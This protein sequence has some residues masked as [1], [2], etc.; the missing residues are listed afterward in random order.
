MPFGKGEVKKVGVIGG[1]RIPFARA[2]TAYNNIAPLRL[3][4]ASHQAVVEKYKLKG[5]VLG[6]VA[7]GGVINHSADWNL[8][9][10]SVFQS[11]LS[12][13]TPGVGV[14]RAC[15]TSLEAAIIIGSKIATGQIDS[16]L[17]GGVDSL[18]DVPVVYGRKLARTLL[19]M[20]RAKTFGARIGPFFKLGFRDLKPAFPGVTEPTTGMSMG[21]HCEVM[22]K[23]WKVTREEQDQLA[24]ESHQKAAAAWKD[25]FYSDLVFPFNG[26]ETDNNVRGNT[27]L[28][29]MA[30]LKPAFDRS[31]A[32][33][34]TAANS[35]A[36]TDGAASVLLGTDEWAQSKGLK[37]QAYISDS[38]VAAV[39]IKKE[40][41]LMAPA[42]AVGRML[43]RNNLKLQDF[44]FYE[45][46]EAFAAQ[47]L[48]TLK[49]WESDDFC[50]NR[51][52]LDGAL[53]SIDRSKMNV[54]G[55]S[56]AVGHPF[57]ATG[58]RLVA[59]LAKLLDQKG[60]GRGLISVCTGGGMGVTAILE[61]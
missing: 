52:G 37:V 27:T 57:G 24:F 60:S 8:A 45:I 29:K 7:S 41:L 38:E 55:G 3:L 43:K 26:L 25:G 19:N 6:D 12:W 15:G 17:A 1:A 58:A 31:A 49:A 28:E 35:T 11:G 20:A 4:S 30:K 33:T 40:G 51:I 46:H 59:T 34:L 5:Q 23:D 14:Q 18:S 2:G 61:K 42:Y 21:E 39:D 47:A 50:R 54:V 16:G 36:L 32:G 10:E 53:G 13:D 22:A 56:V 48:C 44:D 9:R